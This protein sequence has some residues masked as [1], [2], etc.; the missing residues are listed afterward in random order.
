[1]A[2]DKADPGLKLSKCTCLKQPISASLTP[3]VHL[4]IYS[5]WLYGHPSHNQ[6]ALGFYE[7]KFKTIYKIIIH[8]PGSLILSQNKLGYSWIVFHKGENTTLTPLPYY[9]SLIHSWARNTKYEHW[10]SRRICQETWL[11]SK[12]CGI[13]TM[14][15]IFLYNTVMLCQPHWMGQTWKSIPQ[16][17]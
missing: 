9:I 5:S 8:I 12:Q 14:W 13:V 11:A 3:W 15:H 4:I 1:M 2:I 16:K 17:D 7:T 10:C 6:V